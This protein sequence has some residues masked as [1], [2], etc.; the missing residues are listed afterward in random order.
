MRASICCSMSAWTRHRLC[1]SC[2]RRMQRIAVTQ[3][4]T[5]AKNRLQSTIQAGTKDGAHRRLIK[6]R[7]ETM[8]AVSRI[9]RDRGIHE[10][11]SIGTAMPM[12]SRQSTSRIPPIRAAVIPEVRKLDRPVFMGLA[13]LFTFLYYSPHLNDSA[14]IMPFRV[15]LYSSARCAEIVHP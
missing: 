15:M 5:T 9:V 2:T 14:R 13:P 1:S 6:V 4:T 10:E 11:P 3:I 12:D 7:R 8:V